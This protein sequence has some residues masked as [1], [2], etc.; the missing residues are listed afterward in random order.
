LNWFQSLGASLFGLNDYITEQWGTDIFMLDP[1][2]DF[3]NFTNDKLKVLAVFS[4]P[5]VL[6]VFKLQCDMFSMGEVYVYRNGKPVAT[7]PF[8]T[9]I[10]NPNPFQQKSQFLWDYMFWKMIG[11]AYCYVDSD[12]AMSDTNKLYMLDS[13]KMI[14]P[15]DMNQYKDRIVLSKATELA[16]ND[17]PIA[18]NYSNGTFDSFKWGRITHIPDLSNGN[19]NWFRGN[20]T[21]DALYQIIANSKASAKS[22]N[23]TVRYAGKYMVAGQQ[24]PNN[25]QQL[26]LSSEEQQSIESK[27]NGI[28]N[29]HAVKSM[30]DIKR[31]VESSAVIGDLDKSYWDDYFKVGSLFGIP[32]DVLEASL[33]GSTYENQEIARGAH[34][35]YTLQPAGDQFM[36]ALTKRFGY[37]T[38][39][40]VISWDHLP[41]TNAGAKLKAQADLFV[42]QALI[43][44]M[45][46]GVKVEEIN[47]I[48]DTEFTELNYDTA[49]AS[50]GQTNSSA[51]DQGSNQQQ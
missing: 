24:D 14:F 11:N 5:A 4:N 23:I 51:T 44:F 43:N 41:F 50:A 7:D 8:I 48:L 17:I 40:I 1:N 25:V 10:N 3:T 2:A 39:S 31:F 34:V 15:A 13:S 32:R 19:G 29:V 26:P 18:Y 16:I 30:I 46:A 36:N 21:I 33:S 38:K 6:K 47:H 45:K 37:T 49:N 12:S 28:K 27:M 42:S 35:D 22:K 20:S 9:L